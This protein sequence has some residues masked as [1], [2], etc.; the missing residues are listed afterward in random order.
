MFWFGNQSL[1]YLYP[2]LFN[3]V[4]KKHATVAKVLSTNPLNVSFRRALFGDKLLEWHTMV[5]SLVHINLNG[6]TDVFIW[7][8]HK[9]GSFSVKSMYLHLV[10]SGVK[11]SQENM[12]MKIPLKIKVF[13]YYLK[14]GVILTKD[15]L[16][17]RN[18]GGNKTSLGLAPPNTVANMFDVW[19]KMVQQL[20][21]GQFCSQGMRVS[22]IISNRNLFY[23]Y[24]SRER[25]LHYVHHE[26]E[27][28][29]LHR[30]IFKANNIMLDSDFRARSATLASPAQWLSSVT[31]IAG[32]WGYIAPDYAMSYKATRQTDIYAFGLLVLEVVTGKKNGDMIPPDDDHITDWIWRLHREG[33]LLDAVDASLLAT[34]TGDDDK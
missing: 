14:Q 27:P 31:S 24:F 23:G 2:N 11:V 13:M 21:A 7:G 29:V 30:D 32:T 17:R 19:A 8:L 20:F 16:A 6:D 25:S 10:N 18:W 22:L 12:Q 28:M 4:R 15:N 1:K 9:H 33:K 5:A 3:I 26:H 34:G